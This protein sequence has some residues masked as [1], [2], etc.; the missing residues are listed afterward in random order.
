MGEG[1]E[2]EKKSWGREIEI[3]LKASIESEKIQIE[4]PWP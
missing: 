1:E 4:V 2:K 3:L